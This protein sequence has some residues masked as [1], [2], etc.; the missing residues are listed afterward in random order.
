MA[1]KTEDDVKTVY[2][3]AWRRDDRQVQCNRYTEQG[4]R[5]RESGFE[6]G[7]GKGWDGLLE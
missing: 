1:K 2:K 7:K 6:G 4:E 5:G 3:D